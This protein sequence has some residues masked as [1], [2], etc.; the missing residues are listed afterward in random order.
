MHS[1][2]LLSRLI[3]NEGQ[4]EIALKNGITI[5]CYPC[6]YVTVRGISI[7]C[8]ICD[9]MAFW[10]HEETAANPEQEVLDALR[11]GM[12]TFSTAK[13]IKISTPYR[14]EGI[15]WH[16][17]QRRAELDHL[18]WQ[19]PSPAMNPAL[20]ELILEK[21]RKR[22]E[23]T[24]RREYLAEF[25]DDINGWIVPEVLDPCILPG[26]S[27]LPHIE[28][29]RYVAAID[30]AFSHSD[31]ALAV[32][33]QTENG[34][35]VVDRV[36]RWAGTKKAPLAYEWVC[37]EILAVLREYGI[38]NVLSDQYCAPVISQHLQTLG[39]HFDQHSF[40]SHTRTD[41]F[42]NLK[43]LIVQRQIELLDDPVLLRQL[44]AL[45][46]HR[47]PNGNIDIRPAHGQK[48]DLAVVVALA[49]FELA[50][51]PIIRELWAPVFFPF[52]E[53]DA[54]WHVISGGFPRPGR[55]SFED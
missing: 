26:R 32:L 34:P 50:N 51:K 21:A 10:R 8:V 16:E 46:E 44:R 38:N 41:I 55:A 5:A 3:A 29:A 2:P 23:Q 33:H 36:A 28:N 14:K 20:D 48:D 45:E 54:S 31:F 49:A 17:F 22:D 47:T 11:P 25:T 39:I 18:V 1:S 6:S 4:N 27:A 52:R 30:P 42:G 40:G 9:E 7:V 19:L 35:I 43:H 53:R 37:N 24:F 12:S 13:L 15:L